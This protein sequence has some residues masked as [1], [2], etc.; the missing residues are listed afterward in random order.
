[1]EQP[2]FLDS[3]N[4][5]D[6]IDTF[7]DLFERG[8]V[9]SKDT[10]K[11]TA[12]ST[13]IDHNRKWIYTNPDP[14][15]DCGMM[16][17]IFN[18]LGFTPSRCRECWKVVVKMQTVKQLLA[19]YEFQKEFT[20]KSKGSARF[21]KCG[22]EQRAYVHYQYGGYFYCDSLDQGQKRYKEVRDAV[23]KIDPTIEVTLKRGC[24]E[25]EIKNGSTKTDEKPAYAEEI[26]RHIDEAFD[27]RNINVEQPPY[28]IKHILKEWLLFAWD[29]GDKTAIEFNNGKPFYT[30]C[31]TYHEEAGTNE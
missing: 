12:R 29:R 22:I 8:W 17:E 31:V 2:S 9:I 15:R 18:R 11:I 25:M 16:M 14:N 27:Y 28:L 6:V 13:A 20:K 21:C 19:L 10:G 4:A 26:E 1:M 24:T 23:N 5:F 30:Q 7:G 3:L